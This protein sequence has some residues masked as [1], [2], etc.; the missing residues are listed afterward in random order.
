MFYSSSSHTIPTWWGCHG[1]TDKL[2]MFTRIQIG[3]GTSSGGTRSCIHLPV[4]SVVVA[5]IVHSM[6]R[7]LGRWLPIRRRH[8][9][10]VDTY[11][12]IIVVGMAW[13]HHFW[14]MSWSSHRSSRSRGRCIVVVDQ[15]SR[16]R[17]LW[18]S[19]GGPV[20]HVFHVGRHI[21]QR[22]RCGCHGTC[23]GDGKHGH[24]HVMLLLILLE[25]GGAGSRRRCRLVVARNKACN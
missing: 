9:L 17:W 1:G 15:G 5:W 11:S 18:W 21:L 3:I 12:Y 25:G 10:L 8:G 23:I 20:P 6:M 13:W 2:C 22:W 4:V 7:L 24:H 16:M 19:I 14:M